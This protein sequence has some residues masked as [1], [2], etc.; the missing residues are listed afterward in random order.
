M[1]HCIQIYDYWSEKNYTIYMLLCYQEDS[2]VPYQKNVI[3]HL[4]IIMT[5]S[6]E[7]VNETNSKE[8]CTW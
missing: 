1:Q 4:V 3:N 2:S 8:E 7:T 5:C 6:K